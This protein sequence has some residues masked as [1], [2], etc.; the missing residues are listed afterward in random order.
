M[1]SVLTGGSF[2]TSANSCAKSDSAETRNWDE[3]SL[4]ALENKCFIKPIFDFCLR[5]RINDR[6]GIFCRLHVNYTR[7]WLL[8]EPEI[9]EPPAMGTLRDEREW[10][11]PKILFFPASTA[12]IVFVE[13][14]WW[15]VLS[16]FTSNQS[17]VNMQKALRRKQ[18][19]KRPSSQLLTSFTDFK[20]SKLT[21]KKSESGEWSLKKRN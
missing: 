13:A 15:P 8:A 11:W 9:V 16:T 12:S 20:R 2:N 4:F 14:Y 6:K 1:V 10:C 5:N 18:F 17:R 7:F 19:F 3:N 21:F